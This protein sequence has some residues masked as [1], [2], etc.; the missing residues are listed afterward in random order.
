[1]A[2]AA[3]GALILLGLGADLLMHG[4]PGLGLHQFALMGAGVVL[5]LIAALPPRS[6]ENLL[7]LLASLALALGGAEVILR[8]FYASEFVAPY[9]LHPRYLYTLRPGITRRF[10]HLPVNGGH[11]VTFH[12]NAEGFR[13]EPLRARD[14][15]KRIVIYGD[16]FIQAE[17]T[18]LADTFAEQLERRLASRVRPGVEVV[19]AGVTAYGPD[20]AC[21]RIEDE[22]G[23]L[24]PDLVILAIFADN[25][26]GDLVRNK[27]F[28]L[29]ADGRLVENRFR[30]TPKLKDTWKEADTGLYLG[31]LRAKARR[32]WL[33]P[34]AAL[35]GTPAGR[36][37]TWLYDRR[38]E[39]DQFVNKGNNDVGRLLEDSY[40]ADVSLTPD[41]ASARYKIAL[42]E[43]VLGRIRTAVERHGKPLM[44]LVIPSP[45]DVVD[46][47]DFGQ[48]DPVL[49]PQYRRETLTGVV[50]AMASRL[51][52]PCLNLFGPFR[53]AGPDALYLHGGDN[54]WNDAGQALA[55]RMAADFILERLILNSLAPSHAFLL[56]PVRRSPIAG[57]S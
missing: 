11:V 30:F 16:S 17:Y 44:L 5:A 45:I 57:P 21:R 28:R 3:G 26:L 29:G 39:Y 42:M 24:D 56:R 52:I 4:S 25:D 2:G 38:E 18:E 36:I 20:Q 12:V 1:M 55:A 15:Q 49:Y 51:G 19:N 14:G 40:D 7:L 53:A 10:H 13:G 9:R 46:G 8:L 23:R 32:Q 35:R 48:V 41:S 6:I 54:H 43:A 34:N 37:R 33:D 31:K 47:Y 50:E 22:L 27:I